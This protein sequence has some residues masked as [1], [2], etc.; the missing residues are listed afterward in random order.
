MSMQ[1]R[2][3]KGLVTECKGEEWNQFDEVELQRRRSF[4]ERNATWQMMQLSSTY[5]INTSC[6]STTTTTSRILAE[7]EAEAT[8]STP[9]MFSAGGTIRRSMDP[10]KQLIKTHNDL[11]IFVA[12]YRENSIGHGL[13]NHFISNEEDHNGCGDSHQT[14]QLFPLCSSGGGESINDKETENSSASVAAA[15]NANFTTTHQF[16]EFLP[17]KN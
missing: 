15:M 5:L 10:N 14:L 1:I 13:I 9:T 7:A 8:A 11:N 16:F 6:S 3:A 4:M 12:P 2:A 17:L